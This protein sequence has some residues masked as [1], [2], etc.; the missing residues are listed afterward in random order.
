MYFALDAGDQLL[1]DRLHGFDFGDETALPN[2]YIPNP[3]SGKMVPDQI[4][5]VFRAYT[6][7]DESICHFADY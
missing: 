2:I 4:R 6:L 5:E 7:D 3:I 1:P